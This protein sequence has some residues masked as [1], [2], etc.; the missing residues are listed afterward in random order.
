MG[1]LNFL[2]II[3]DIIDR[4]I[5]DKNA[6]AKAKAELELL[7]QSGEL[8]LMLEQIKVNRQ[9]ARHKDVFVAGWRPFIGWICGIS[10]IIGAVV[11]LVIPALA[12][13]IMVYGDGDVAKLNELADILNT[14][15][16][17]FFYPILG[18]LLGLGA[19]RTYEKYKGVN[20]R[21]D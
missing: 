3:S 20:S 21:H 1:F 16:V 18:G 2:P 7:E 4:L 19:M 11:K 14:I 17:E 6:A 9:E 5:P 12:A 13:V 15:D 10:L 8:Q